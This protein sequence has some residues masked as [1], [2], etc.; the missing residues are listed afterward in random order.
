MGLRVTP[1]NFCRIVLGIVYDCHDQVFGH[2]SIGCSFRLRLPEAEDLELAGYGSD[3][4]RRLMRA[5][6]FIYGLAVW[7]FRI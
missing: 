3:Y 7:G 5:S 4:S 2:L 1:N 6:L